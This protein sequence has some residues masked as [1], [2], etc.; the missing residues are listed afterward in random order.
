[1]F[2]ISQY[3]ENFVLLGVYVVYINIFCA[4]GVIYSSRRINSAL[5]TLLVIVLFNLIMKYAQSEMTPMFDTHKELIRHLWYLIFATCWLSSVYVMNKIHELSDV[6]LGKFAK[7][8]MFAN[9][10]IGMLTLI[11]YIFRMHL[12]IDSP[13]INALYSFGINIMNVAIAAL[14][15]AISVTALWLNT[16]LFKRTR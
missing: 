4:V 8:V 16:S 14:S 5:I 11:K 12:E 7:T 3:Y 10:S 6:E 9:L 13:I 2:D 15:L 1:M